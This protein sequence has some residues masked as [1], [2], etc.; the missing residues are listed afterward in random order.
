LMPACPMPASPMPACATPS[1]PRS[2]HLWRRLGGDRRGL[3]ALEFAL[4]A[5]ILVMAYL[6]TAEA[7]LA[8]MAQ[9][10]LSLSASIAADL[11]SHSATINVQTVNGIFAATTAVLDP[12]DATTLTQRLTGIVVDAAGVARVEW[13]VGAGMAALA[14]G[15]EVAL[16][17]ILV[18]ADEG[19][20]MAETSLDYASPMAFTLP[21]TRQFSETHFVYPRVNDRVLWE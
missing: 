4:I 8:L 18:A 13:S 6:A 16:P 1:R 20:V 12:F 3:A 7:S 21:G 14:T 17:A 10:K 2:G 15:S 11:A 19:I 5:P 9:C